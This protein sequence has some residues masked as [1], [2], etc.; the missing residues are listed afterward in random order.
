MLFLFFF[1]LYYYFISFFPLLSFFICR[2]IYFAWELMVIGVEKVF[3]KMKILCLFVIPMCYC[4][5]CVFSYFLFSS[6]AKKLFHF[7]RRNITFIRIELT[8]WLWS[9]AAPFTLNKDFIILAQATAGL[10]IFGCYTGV[11]VPIQHCL[12]ARVHVN[13]TRMNRTD[14]CKGSFK[15]IDLWLF[16]FNLYPCVCAYILCVIVA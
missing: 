11:N 15:I 5:V 7:T 3:K 13:F 8:K 10:F 6:F 12:L 1:F 14:L 16:V 2:S 9:S 4:F